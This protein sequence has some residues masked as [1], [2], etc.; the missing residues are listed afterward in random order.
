MNQAA[1]RVDLAQAADN[2][3]NK[4]FVDSALEPF[5]EAKTNLNKTIVDRSRPQKSFPAGKG[6]CAPQSLF[7]TVR[8]IV[9]R[10]TMGLIAKSLQLP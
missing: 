5:K 2:E 1:R 3:F 8:V 4:W 6:A 7:L 9:Y 10:N